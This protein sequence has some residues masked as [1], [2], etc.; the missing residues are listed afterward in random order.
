MHPCRAG[1]L[2]AQA[3]AR[4]ARGTVASTHARAVNLLLDDCFVVAVLPAGSPLHPWALA[5]KFDPSLAREGEAVRV[6]GQVLV[7]GSLTIAL[8]GLVP[9]DLRLRFR[10]LQ[11]PRDPIR[12]VVEF[13]ASPPGEDPFDRRLGAVV[14]AFSE[15]GDAHELASLVGLGVGLTPSGDDVLVGALAAL[16]LV[17]ACS[18]GARPLRQALVE[19]LPLPLEARTTRLSAQM[20]RAAAD[21]LYAEPVL[22]LLDALADGGASPAHVEHAAAALARLGHRSGRDTLLGI[23]AALSRTNARACGTAG[24]GPLSQGERDRVR[25]RQ[26]TADRAQANGPTL[27]PALSQREREAR[28]T[29]LWHRRSPS[30]LPGGEG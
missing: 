18:P 27:T 4:D 8:D 28:P 23:A 21:G 19:S 29:S 11:Q 25:G 20:L 7:A 13:V 26:G 9:A 16:D 1:P 14:C 17:S 24:P 10:P 30:P 3:L 2:A 22:D 12:Y 5:T 15:G 6:S